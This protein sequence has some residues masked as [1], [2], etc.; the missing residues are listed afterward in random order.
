MY[1]KKINV[2][3]N[4]YKFLTLLSLIDSIENML[5]FYLYLYL[6]N[7]IDKYITIKKCDIK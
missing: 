1:N 2:F 6:I 7:I 3:N 5:L 4:N